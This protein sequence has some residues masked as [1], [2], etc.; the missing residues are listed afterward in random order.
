M[1]AIPPDTFDSIQCTFNGISLFFQNLFQQGANLPI[2]INNKNGRHRFDS[3][4]APIHIVFF[5]MKSKGKDPLRNV[6]S[7]LASP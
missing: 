2:I 6:R 5:F 4:S 3:F 1:A 7:T